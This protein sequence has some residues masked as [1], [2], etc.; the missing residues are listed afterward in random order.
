VGDIYIDTTGDDAYIAVGTASSADWEK[1][2]D[3]AGGGISD[4]DKGDITVSGSGATWTIDND[5][6]TYAKMQNVSATDKV[7][8]RTTAGAGD[9]E[10]I[11][12]TGSGNV[13]RAT[14]PTLVTPVLGAATATTINGA[15]IT[16][17]TLNGT[18]TGTNTGDQT[19][20]V[21]ITGT[22]AQFDTAVSDGNIVYQSQ[23]LGTPSGGTLTNCTGL[24]VNGI[25]DDTTSALGVGTLEL[26]HATDTTVSRA[27]AGIIAVEG[28]NQVNVSTAQ[29]L[30][31]KDL[32]ATSNTFTAAST[33]QSGV[34]E[35][36]IASEVNT[37]TDAA[38]YVSPDSLAGSNFGIRYA[39]CTLNG[40]TALTTSEKCYFRIPAALSGM[41][42]VSVTGTVGTGAAGSSSSGTPTFTVKNVTDGNQM[43]T[44][45]LTID[46]GEYTSASAATPVSINTSFDDVVTDDLIEVAVTTAG[47]G[48]TY[49]QI[50][51]GFQLP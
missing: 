16:S 38:R 50:V 24:P 17:G 7:L 20:I 29:V 33:T 23:A 48:V 44:T 11:S 27:S 30:T 25:V 18:V 4:G 40:T 22:M 47:T 3:G 39:Q 5:V 46:A 14:S 42:L 43:L 26:G 49:A 1:S 6:V 31:N 13:V 19:S 28:V 35:A 10:E 37:G 8:G 34:A 32:T 36:S 15:T 41:N 21:G 51:L 9:V 2:N 12:T 45:S